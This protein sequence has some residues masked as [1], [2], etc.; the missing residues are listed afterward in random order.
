MGLSES[1]RPKKCRGLENHVG[2]PISLEQICTFFFHNPAITAV[3]RPKRCLLLNLHSLRSREARDFHGVGFVT[4]H[5]M[6]QN[7]GD[8]NFDFWTPELESYI[9]LV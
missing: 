8:A 6:S 4:C 7:F 2:Y 5:D 3:R 9:P 1:S